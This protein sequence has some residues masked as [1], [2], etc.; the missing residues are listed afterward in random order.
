MDTRPRLALLRSRR[1]GWIAAC[2]LLA[3][4]FAAALLPPLHWALGTAATA[5]AY[6]VGTAVLIT[7][8]IV[9]VYLTGRPAPKDG[10]DQ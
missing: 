5:M 9:A 7:V 8:G 2:A 10:D 4:G 3:A 6:L 1:P